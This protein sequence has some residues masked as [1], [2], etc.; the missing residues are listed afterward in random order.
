MFRDYGAT[1]R[2]H[3]RQDRLKSSPIISLSGTGD[4]FS[5]AEVLRAE[6]KLLPPSRSRRAL[7]AVAR[8]IVVATDSS[9]MSGTNIT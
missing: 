8:E 4:S 7:L 9:V 3:P 2:W 5:Y 1:G 6:S